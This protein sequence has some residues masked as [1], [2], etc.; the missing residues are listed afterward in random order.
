MIPVSEPKL[1]KEEKNLIQNCLKTNWISSQGPYVSKFEKNFAKFHK[2]KYAI[3]VS[4]CTTALHLSL[5]ALGIKKGDEVICPSLSFISP[6]NMIEHVGAKLVLVDVNNRDLNIDHRLIEREI[7]K[8][9]KAI[10]VVHQFGNPSNLREILK[11]CKKFKIKL[12]EDNAE[13]IGSKF[14]NKLTGTFGDVSTFSFFGNKILTT[15]EGGMII[16]NNKRYY[17]KIKILRDHGLVD[18][19]KYLHKYLGFNY[20]MTNLQAAI[21]IGQLKNIKIILKNKDRILFCYKKYL[22]K[23]SLIK[24]VPLEKDISITSV[25]W[26]VTIYIPTI[27]KIKMTKLISKLNNKGVDIRRMIQPIY[28][29]GH[30]KNKFDKKKYKI[31]EEFS[32]KSIHLPSSINLNDSKIRFICSLLVSELKKVL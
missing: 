32:Y 9:T 1:F 19:K 26:L 12:I 10:I 6:A 8:R 23:N 22:S 11:I 3:S 29:A 31:S 14:M 16:T 20:R 21:G 4:N 27:S 24:I 15:G 28:K 18:K 25:N 2:I 13:A 7:T 5:L 17:Q 30:F